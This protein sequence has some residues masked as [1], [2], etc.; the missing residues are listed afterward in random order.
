MSFTKKDAYKALVVG[1]LVSLFML[2]VI[3]N[4]AFDLPFSKYWLSVVF[5]PLSFAG[6]YISYLI[7]KAWKPFVYQFGKFFVVGTLNTFMD[8]GI[9]NALIYFTNITQGV[10][11]S[12][13]KAA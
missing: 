12:A 5:P 6:L 1:F 13:F 2:I 11:F 9:L 3:K 4:L 7:S 8:L 10:Y